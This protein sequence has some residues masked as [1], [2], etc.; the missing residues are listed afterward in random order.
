MATKKAAPVKKASPP[1]KKIVQQSPPID[2]WQARDD[3]R[4][5]Q[6]AAEIQSDAKRMKAAQAEAQSQI[7][8]LSKVSKK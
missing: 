3:L 1:A 6:A 7:A 5:V 8:A 2:R 4:T